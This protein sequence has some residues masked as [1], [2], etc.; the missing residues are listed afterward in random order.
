[1]KEEIINPKTLI[2][3]FLVTID[4]LQKELNEGNIDVHTF[5]EEIVLLSEFI[6]NNLK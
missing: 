4:S 5:Y 3:T 2:T 6:K 1:M